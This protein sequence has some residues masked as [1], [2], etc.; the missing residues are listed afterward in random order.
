MYN[1]HYNRESTTKYEIE[2]LQQKIC[3]LISQNVVVNLTTNV[4]DHKK[5]SKRQVEV[6]YVFQPIFIK[7]RIVTSI[8]NLASIILLVNKII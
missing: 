2:L 3:I 8:F 4:K 6:Q 5:K 1:A 7:V